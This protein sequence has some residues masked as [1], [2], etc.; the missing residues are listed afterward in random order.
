LKDTTVKKSKTN[1]IRYIYGKELLATLRARDNLFTLTS[2][3]AKRLHRILK[4]P[5]Y[6]VMASEQVVPFILEGRDLLSKFAVS[7][8]TDLRAYEEVLVIDSND[9]LLGTGKLML[10]PKELE[11]FERG[12][13]VKIRATVKL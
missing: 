8:D 3:G 11:Y 1:R 7:W 13:A 5:Y 4:Y 2:E 10:S 6:R 12:V 9:F